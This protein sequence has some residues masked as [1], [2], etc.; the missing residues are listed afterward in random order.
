MIILKRLDLF[1]GHRNCSVRRKIAVQR[2]AIETKVMYG[3]EAL[4]LP[5]SAVAKLDVFQLKG[6]RKILRME[7]TYVNRGN[8]NEEV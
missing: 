1:W 4:Q 8:T 2:A 3:L 7:T 6:L 5:K